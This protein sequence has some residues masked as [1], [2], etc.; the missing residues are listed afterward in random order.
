MKAVANFSASGVAER[1]ARSRRS[2]GSRADSRQVKP[3]LPVRGAAGRRR[4]HGRDFRGSS[5][6]ERRRRRAERRRSWRRS[7]FRRTSS[8]PNARA[9]FAAG[10]VVVLIRAVRRVLVGVTGT[11]GKSSTVD[12]LRQIW[13]HAGKRAASLGTLG[14]IWDG[15]RA[16][17]SA[18]PPPI[19]SRLHQTLQML[20]DEG[21]THAAM[22]VSSHGLEQHRVDGVT[23]RRR[24]LHQ[25][26]AGSPRLSPDDGRPIATPSCASGTLVKRRR[27]RRDQRRR[28]PKAERVRSSAREGSAALDVVLCGWR[29]PREHA[30]KIVEIQPRPERADD[31][32]AMGRRGRRMSSCR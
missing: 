22:E 30:L 2:P 6:G 11:N 8:A 28:S 5:Q 14:A 12:F 19:R 20:A 32:A 29:A 23:L 27:R 24:R 3:R 4:A 15:R 10:G 17:I 9:D 21:V 18:T 1:R 13:A 31:D 16:S 26:D 7:R 25:S